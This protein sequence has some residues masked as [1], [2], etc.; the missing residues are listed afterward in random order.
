MRLKYADRSI[1]GE[2]P[3]KIHMA[4][5][6]IIDGIQADIEKRVGFKCPVQRIATTA[7]LAFDA[8]N[9]QA[10]YAQFKEATDKTTNSQRG[11]KISLAAMKHLL[12]QRRYLAHRWSK[13][14]GQVSLAGL[15]TCIILQT[16]PAILTT[17]EPGI[18]NPGTAPLQPDVPDT[19]PPAS[20][21]DSS[22]PPAPP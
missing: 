5:A 4:A 18:S 20:A 9:Y 7:V 16:D 11:I 8:K 6:V 17:L 12:V 14:H 13:L 1:V 10:T 19:T 15:M 2:C 3:V 21:S 22:P